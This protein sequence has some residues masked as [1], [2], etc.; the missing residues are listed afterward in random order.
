MCKKKVGKKWGK[1]GGEKSG[2]KRGG[3]TVVGLQ[4]PV[5]DAPPVA[6]LQ[7]EHHLGCVRARGGLFERADGF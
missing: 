1:K 2:E 6:V 4:V 5:H 7:R 3:R